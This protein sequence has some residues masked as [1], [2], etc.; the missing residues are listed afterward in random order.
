MLDMPG[1]FAGL[2]IIVTIGFIVETVIFEIIEE[3]TIKK[4]GMTN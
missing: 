3:N 1:V 4:W 2:L